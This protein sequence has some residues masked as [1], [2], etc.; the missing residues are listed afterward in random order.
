[1]EP[2]TIRHQLAGAVGRGLVRAGTWILRR[3]AP[4]APVQ[5]PPEDDEQDGDEEGYGVAL[6]PEAQRLMQEGLAAGPRAADKRPEPPPAGSIAARVK[7]AQG[8]RW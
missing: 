6:S 5:P 3:T 8:P 1:M 4:V 7:R 2:R